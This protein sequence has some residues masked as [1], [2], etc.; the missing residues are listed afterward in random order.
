[1]AALAPAQDLVRSLEE[2]VVSRRAVYETHAR[3]S[4]FAVRFGEKTC[5][6]HTTKALVIGVR[7]LVESGVRTGEGIDFAVLHEIKHY[8]DMRREPYAYQ[9]LIQKGE[10]E[11]GLG[12]LYFRLYNC[13]E[14]IGVNER[15]SHDSALYRDPNGQGFS[16]LVK[17]L[18][19]T[20]LFKER[21]F[22]KRSP[23][24]RHPD[25]ALC[26]Q[27]TDYLLNLGM[28]VGDDIALAPEVKAM[29]ARP[30]NVYGRVLSTEQFIDSYLRPLPPTE[31]RSP[32]NS[33]A[34]RTQMVESFIE[35]RFEELLAIDRQGLGDEKLKVLG[36]D[37][38]FGAPKGSSIEDLREALNI[39][40][41]EVEEGLKTPAQR[42]RDLLRDQQRQSADA[43]G[44]SPVEKEDFVLRLER[45]QPFTEALRDLWMS[46]PQPSTEISYR[47][48]G[49]FPQG[50]R[51]NMHRVVA[52][53]PRLDRGENNVP[54]M[55][56]L[57]EQCDVERAPKL[58]RVR[59][60]VDASGSMRDSMNTVAD[61]GLV[62]AN[63][64]RAANAQADIQGSD[65]RC[66]G[67]VLTFG[68]GAQE[69]VPLRTDMSLADIMRCYKSYFVYEGDTKDHLAL[70]LLLKQLAPK[71]IALRKAGEIV[72]IVIEITDG[73]TA[74]PHETRSAIEELEQNGLLVRAISIGRF[75]QFER[76]WGAR[77][78][79]LESVEQLF[80]VVQDLLRELF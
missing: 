50:L 78:R 41:K 28:G 61:L 42:S 66:A 73:M 72:D 80:P 71:D 8:L 46:I 32:A 20:A 62:L 2:A 19:R 76:I 33:L 69:I 7:D 22:D 1:M 12:G 24:A 4:G 9:K 25:R 77:G 15:N 30:I 65:F 10:R 55:E 18:Y 43:A 29:I 70:Q 47:Y 35:P 27:Y 64:S 21:N 57:V 31:G 53:F 56:Q 3:D 37:G 79:P 74:E 6:D 13:T 5:F 52:E 17:S 59:L 40:L 34:T 14:D 54:V 23:G 16:D 63:S 39:I 44:L 68:A 36:A 26:Q 60:L 67:Q 58:V 38:Q 51:P 11:D 48:V 49:D 75:A 45:L